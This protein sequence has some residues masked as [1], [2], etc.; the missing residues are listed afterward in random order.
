MHTNVPEWISAVGDQG[1]HPGMIGHWTSPMPSSNC[2]PMGPTINDV[3]EVGPTPVAIHSQDSWQHVSQDNVSAASTQEC[4]SLPIPQ[5][6]QP[7]VVP[8]VA[9][10]HTPAQHDEIMAQFKLYGLDPG[11]AYWIRCPCNASQSKY[12]IKRHMEK[13]YQDA[14]RGLWSRN[15]P[16]RCNI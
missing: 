1:K 10:L 16:K 8:R 3:P 13:L 6:P 9:P 14:D 4:L 2:G 15:N 12:V 11:P 7:A 5:R